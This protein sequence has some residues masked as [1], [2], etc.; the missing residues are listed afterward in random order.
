MVQ[1]E[2]TP[3]MIKVSRFLLVFIREIKLLIPGIR[4]KEKGLVMCQSYFVYQ[5]T[6]LMIPPTL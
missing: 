5:D 3:A 6:L 1:V 2:M 4:S